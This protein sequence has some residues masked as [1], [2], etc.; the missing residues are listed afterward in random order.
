M[1]AFPHGGG[2]TQKQF[3]DILVRDFIEQE[4]IEDKR[5]I[6]IAALAALL[7]RRRNADT[8]SSNSVRRSLRDDL[9]HIQLTKQ[10]ETSYEYY[11]EDEE[12]DIDEDEEEEEDE[13]DDEDDIDDEEDSWDDDIFP[14]E[15]V[16][17]PKPEPIARKRS[18][19]HDETPRPAPKDQ[20]QA[21]PMKRQRVDLPGAANKPTVQS[22]PKPQEKKKADP[23][24]TSNGWKPVYTGKTDNAHLPP[25]L[26]RTLH[27]TPMT[28]IHPAVEKALLAIDCDAAGAEDLANAF[29]DMGLRFGRVATTAEYDIVL[30]QLVND[31]RD[32]IRYNGI[33]EYFK[34]RFFWKKIQRVTGREL[35]PDPHEEFRKEREK[36][37]EEERAAARRVALAKEKARPA[38]K[39]SFVKE[40]DEKTKL[41]LNERVKKWLEDIVTSENKAK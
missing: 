37:L 3:H 33:N 17:Q 5:R 39:A 19:P 7:L 32:P 15:E 41:P 16:T 34:H 10:Y 18:V 12:E 40:V 22:T 2:L 25:L 9:R 13:E 28:M 6:E 30:S 29:I 24:A 27:G 11:D 35:P 26:R 14:V 23:P 20:P 8:E 1:D 21:Q 4:I 38:L 31:Y 36:K